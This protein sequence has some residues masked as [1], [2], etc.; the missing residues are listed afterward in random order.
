[1]T[2]DIDL[3]PPLDIGAA[4]A[5][6]DQNR[7]ELMVEVR[8]ISP[9]TTMIFVYGTL[10]MLVPVAFNAALVKLFS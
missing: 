6:V 9:V 7:A 8:A 3:A 10:M 2:I 5:R 1:M 4:L